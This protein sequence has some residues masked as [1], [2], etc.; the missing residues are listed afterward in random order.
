[1]WYADLGLKEPIISDCDMIRTQIAGNTAVKVKMSNML[2]MLKD[3]IGKDLSKFSLPVFINEP[4]SVLMKPAEQMFFNKGLTN[5]AKAANKS[6]TYR[7]MLVAQ[8][9]I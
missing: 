4:S 6:S 3:M 1:M 9:L 7:M 2:K 5:A 8:S